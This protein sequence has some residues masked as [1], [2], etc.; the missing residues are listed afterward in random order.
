MSVQPPRGTRR[1]CTWLEKTDPGAPA[2]PCLTQ[3]P[4]GPKGSIQGHCNYWL[5]EL[6][7][8]IFQQNEAFA[9][10]PWRNY[11]TKHIYLFNPLHSVCVRV[12]A[13][14]FVCLRILWLHFN[15]SLKS[16]LF[17]T[18][19]SKTESCSLLPQGRREQNLPKTK[20][21]LI[22]FKTQNWVFWDYRKTI[23]LK[24]QLHW[25]R[26]RFPKSL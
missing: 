19:T 8:R 14:A 6:C 20:R 25:E 24:A 9:T 10:L 12:R 21:L 1:G 18:S 16:F 15:F 7:S 4:W 13:R 26:K 2:G 5:D 17:Q 11:S 22:S 23:V 3:P